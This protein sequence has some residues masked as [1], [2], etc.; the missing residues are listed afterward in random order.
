MTFQQGAPALVPR[1]TCDTGS[2]AGGTV[3]IACGDGHAH[4]V[5]GRHVMSRGL[6][7]AHLFRY[8]LSLDS[9]A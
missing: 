6:S 8:A 3:S 4:W 2:N 9:M 5:A 7:A 1:R